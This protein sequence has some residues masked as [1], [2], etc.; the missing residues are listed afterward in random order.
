M[1]EGR[2]RT[3]KDGIQAATKLNGLYTPDSRRL[4]QKTK[5]N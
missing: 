1:A 2:P 3:L 5:Q 4:T